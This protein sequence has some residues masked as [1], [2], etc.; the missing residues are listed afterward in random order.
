MIQFHQHTKVLRTRDG[1]LSR[2]LTQAVPSDGVTFEGNPPD[3]R[4]TQILVPD[5]VGKEVGLLHTLP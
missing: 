5:E 4:S 3:V 1:M 2:M